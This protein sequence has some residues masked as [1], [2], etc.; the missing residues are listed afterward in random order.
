MQEEKPWTYSHSQL[1]LWKLCKRKYYNT[2]LAEGRKKAKPTE[3]M[4]AGT[5]LVQNPIEH[6]EQDGRKD[7]DLNFWNTIWPNFLAEAGLHQ[8]YDHPLFNMDLAKT[9]LK[10]YKKKPLLGKVVQIEKPFVKELAIGIFYKSI[11]D[12]VTETKIPYTGSDGEPVGRTVIH[13][14]DIKLKTFSQSRAGDTYY[15]MPTLPSIND[16]GLGQ[17]ICSGAE[18]FGQI[19][20]WLGRKDGQVI[21][22]VYLEQ[23]RN[24]TL[25]EEWKSETV[26]EC[27]SIEQWREYSESAPWPKN[28]NNC[29]AFNQPCQFKANCNFGFTA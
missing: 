1:A 11:P 12:L 23:T 6:F 3:A 2:Y 8:S 13:A 21:G 22:P 14:W 29:N 15:V 7:D 25:I 20:F 27:R 18:T 4:A 10:A 26:A 19:Q 17:M 28:D 24:L 5:W 9:V 16:Q